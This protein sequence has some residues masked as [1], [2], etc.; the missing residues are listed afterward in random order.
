MDKFN[1]SKVKNELDLISTQQ[2]ILLTINKLEE[3]QS[4][5]SIISKK[6]GITVS[7]VLQLVKTLKKAKIID[8]YMLGRKKIIRLTLKGQRITEL[9]QK[10]KEEI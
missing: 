4:Y 1:K 9:T 10:L 8:T 7:H 3:Q 5:T 2:K 6:T